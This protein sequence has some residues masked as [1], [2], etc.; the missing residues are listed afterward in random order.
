MCY[1]KVGREY[2]GSEGSAQRGRERRSKIS[3]DRTSFDLT[4][5]EWASDGDKCSHWQRTGLDVPLILGDDGSASVAVLVKGP[6]RMRE[7]R[8][9]AD[10]RSMGVGVR[11]QG[12]VSERG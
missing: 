8:D 1:C 4:S 10:C 6:V 7:S 12:A 3:H 2:T 11:R 9:N 5:A